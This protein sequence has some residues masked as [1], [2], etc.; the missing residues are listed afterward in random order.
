[1]TMNVRRALPRWRV[2]ASLLLSAGI[3][4]A[5]DTKVTLTGEEEVPAVATSARGAGTIFASA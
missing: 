2:A 5:G 3:A 1:M 4:L